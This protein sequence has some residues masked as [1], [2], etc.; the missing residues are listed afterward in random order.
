[1]S[2]WKFFRPSDNVAPNATI[3]TGGTVNM[4]YP[5]ANAP[6]LDYANLANPSLLTGTSG[7][8]IFDFGSAQRVDWIVLWHNFDAALACSFSGNATNSWGGPTITTALTIPSK[9]ADDYTVKIHKDLTGVSGYSASGFRYWRLNVTGTNTVP[10]GIKILL[11]STSRST[12]RNIR[13]GG[14][15]DEHQI[16]INQ[17]TDAGHPWSYPL[18]GGRSLRFSIR[19][20][21]A[22]EVILKEWHRSCQGSVK[23]TV[24][25]PDPTVNDAYLVRWGAGMFGPIDPSLGVHTLSDQRTYRNVHDMQIGFDEITAGDPEWY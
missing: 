24:V 17:A 1:M 7:D 2:N 25:I 22:D 23:P 13:W 8:W 4:S 21:D 20:T 16:S 19:P 9:R 5:L 14:N 3:T 6:K 15:F 11:F 10:I 12:T 18:G